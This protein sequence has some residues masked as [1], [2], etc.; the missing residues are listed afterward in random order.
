MP[1][2]SNSMA[3]KILLLWSKCVL[4]SRHRSASLRPSHEPI[5]PHQF[6]LNRRHKL[7]FC[8]L[9]LWI[10]CSRNCIFWGC[11][12]Y[13]VLV[14]V[15]SEAHWAMRW[16]S[17]GLCADNESTSGS[18]L[19]SSSHV[20]IDF[21]KRK[22]SIL[23]TVFAFEKFECHVLRQLGIF[24]LKCKEWCHVLFG[25]IFLTKRYPKIPAFWGEKIGGIGG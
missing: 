7:Y 23:Q 15:W 17:L 24:W 11:R 22:F 5:H 2:G 25:G 8:A 3:K 1:P 21:C 9:S 16:C 6:A 19:S 13:S 18:G 12:D 20:P 10:A 4:P 14:F